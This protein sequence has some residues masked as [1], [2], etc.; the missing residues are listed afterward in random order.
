MTFLE[1]IKCYCQEQ[2]EPGA[3]LFLSVIVTLFVYLVI[4][5]DH[6]LPAF[7]WSFLIP[8]LST[9]LLLI[10][11]RISD[12]FKDIKTDQ[13]F[14]PDRPIPSGR[15]F[16]SDLKIM[17]MVVSIASIG[18]NLIY[19]SALKEFIFA[20]LFTAAMGKWFFMEKL[21][22]GNRLIAFFTHAPV[23]ILLYWYAEVYLLNIHGLSWD[24]P[25]MTTLIAFIILPGLSW[26]VLRKTYLPE[27]EMP[28]YQIYSTMLGFR[29]SLLFASFWVVLT[30]FNN[31][32][33][34]SLF[35]AMDILMYPLLLINFSLL[36][37]I[38]LHG[39]RPK[40]KNL[41]SVA[42]LYMGL[43]LLLPLAVVIYQAWGK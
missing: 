18:I 37:I 27:D 22:S 5:I 40:L 16:L 2:L 26:E 13:K 7:N 25:E 15:L 31:L 41:K 23:G 17:L 20:F 34:I 29:G 38:F 11:Y 9:F 43:H 36:L 10:Y 32:I 21:I 1:R 39:W 12:E 33:M 14:F 42:E 19:P 4:K 3:R 24:L 8:A 35:E 28:G 6:A 30:L